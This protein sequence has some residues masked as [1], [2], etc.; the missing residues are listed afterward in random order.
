MFGGEEGGN[1]LYYPAGGGQPR[2]WQST[3]RP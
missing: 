2:S 3:M 1:T